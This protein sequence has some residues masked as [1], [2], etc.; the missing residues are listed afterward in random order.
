MER[1]RR[2][3]WHARDQLQ[4]PLGRRPA[5]GEEHADGPIDEAS[6]RIGEDR[7]RAVVEPLGIVDRQ[8]ERCPIG[9]AR[10]SVAVATDSVR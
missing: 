7:C 2:S 4:R 1:S 5:D 10:S 6:D 8:D 9:Q 3:G